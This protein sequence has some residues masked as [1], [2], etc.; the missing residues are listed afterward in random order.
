MTGSGKTEVYLRV[1]E[2]ALARGRGGL[3]L[4]P[5][6]A[7]TPQ[8]VSR[9]R[10]RFGDGIAV[11]HS[12]LSE[13]ERDDA[14]RSLRSGA[15]RIAVGARSAL[16]APVPELGLVLVD[17][18]H[19]PSFKQEEGFRYHARDMALLRA[20]RAKGVAVLGSATPSLE[21]YARA[22]EES[23]RSS[24]SSGVPPDRRCPTSRSSICAAT[25]RR[26]AGI[27]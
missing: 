15:V 20:A 19:D 23:S 4:V 14:W 18:E 25:N 22:E 2:E 16:F 24:C 9:V 26:P 5:E 27:R 11:L 21:T 13:R 6:I 1:L 10:S 7:L 17:E 8:L 12:A 3:L